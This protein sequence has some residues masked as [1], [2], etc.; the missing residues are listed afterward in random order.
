MPDTSRHGEKTRSY[1]AILAAALLFSAI[2]IRT[3]AADAGVP[4][5]PALADI[6]ARAYIV[7]DRNT[8][9]TILSHNASERIHPASLTKILTS[10]IAIESLQRDDVITTSPNAADRIPG[11]SVIGLAAGE[12]MTLE[13][14][15]YGM[16]L[17]SGND[18][19]IAVGETISGSASSFADRMNTKS[20][21]I[22][23]TG[24]HWT[25]PP[26]LT[27]D[28]H[29]S[30]AADLARITCY[31]MKNELF[32]KIVSTP[33][34]SLPPTNK[35]P[36]TDWNVLENTNELVRLQGTS[37]YKSPW[38]DEFTGVKTGTT[39]AAGSNR[40]AAAHMKNGLDLVCVVNGVYGDSAES[41]TLY[42]LTLLEEA[43]RT[44]T[45]IQTV[46]S[47]DEPVA[48]IGTDL[49]KY[50]ARSFAVYNPAQKDLQL[51]IRLENGRAI[52][53]AGENVL[54]STELVS[55]AVPASSSASD[56]ASAP[57]DHS[58]RLG[59]ADIFFIVLLSVLGLAAYS[60]VLWLILRRRN[61]RRRKRRSGF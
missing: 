8:G 43:A 61:A 23:T 3:V 14:M 49:E 15:L 50:P 42:A 56:P 26:G 44:A 54:F 58:I 48:E 40:I 5:R 4:V 47:R 18:A 32:R 11:E 53:M 34:Y 35:H 59:N 1:A 30:T 2:G 37:F 38:V 9:E 29:Y 6:D 36:Y 31:A 27:E 55:S 20:A 16:L 17:G 60:L 46:L 22:G 57:A 19:A 45:G 33:V 25:N 41:I 28:G 10:I 39:S 24:S 13:N 7:V 52:V 12:Q 51:E 21:E